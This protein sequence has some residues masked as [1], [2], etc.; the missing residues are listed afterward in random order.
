MKLRFLPVVLLCS[1]ALLAGCGSGNSLDDVGSAS[2]KTGVAYKDIGGGNFLPEYKPA[3]LAPGMVFIEGGTFI[4]GGS[5]ENFAYSNDSR[6]RQVTVTSFLIDETEVS[7]LDWKEFL[8]GVADSGAD[9]VNA[10]VPDK[11]V[12]FR[13]LAYND[14]L[15][16]N[17]FDH[18]G[19]N[20]YP[21][22]GVN[23]YQANAYCAWRTARV[24]EV[25]SQKGRDTV[26]LPSFRLP[27]E[28]EWEYAARGGLE[29]TLY[30]WEG[31]SL[32]NLDGEFLANFK[33]G[34]GDYSGQSNSGRNT[35]E[36]GLN[37]GYSVPAPVRAF[38]PN[39]FGLYNMAGNVAEWTFDTYRKL[40]YEDVEDLNPARRR[41]VTGSAVTAEDQSRSDGG[42]KPGAG[43]YAP[44]PG[45]YSIL[46]RQYAPDTAAGK[47][48][49]RPSR[50][51]LQYYG[52]H[53]A[54]GFDNVKVYRGGSW[55]DVAYYITTGT[56]RFEY[57]DKGTSS[58]GFR[59]AMIRVGSA[60]DA[61]ARKK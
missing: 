25:R 45:G 36:N 7:N 60:P 50:I 22:V 57:A 11:T 53:E 15:L 1:L 35:R 14:P 4:M 16:E 12:W 49:Y 23:W 37:D 41:G 31:K 58:I 2:S 3:E 30:P 21:V 39:D 56:R 20:T 40:S 5:E 44:Q 26:R 17:Y 8:F 43:S 6:A 42:G 19:F 13:D 46:Y 51:E 52:E 55:S 27:T 10:V 33:H 48:I 38:P 34:R 24:N 9:Y 28:A 47:P 29:Q 32:R 18:P 54:D 59:C 61:K